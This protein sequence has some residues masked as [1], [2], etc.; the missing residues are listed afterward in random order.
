MISICVPALASHVDV[1]LF[2]QF[3]EEHNDPEVFEIILVNDKRFGNRKLDKAYDMLQQLYDNITIIDHTMED[4][5]FWL[6]QLIDHYYNNE[7][8]PDDTLDY[9]SNKLG[10]YKKGQLFEVHKKFLWLSSSRLYNL[11]AKHATGDIL[12]FSPADFLY[13]FSLSELNDYVNTHSVDGM[14][15][16]KPHAAWCEVSD[17]ET[18][19]LKPRFSEGIKQFVRIY[20]EPSL[21][22][23]RDTYFMDRK[24]NTPVSL[25]TPNIFD[26]FKE[27]LSPGQDYCPVS[28]GFH[29]FHVMT[30]KSYDTI[31]G[32]TEVAYGRAIGDNAMTHLGLSHMTHNLPNHMCI[33][34]V[35]QSDPI[36]SH[37]IYLHDGKESIAR[38]LEGIIN[39]NDPPIQFNWR[40]NHY[41]T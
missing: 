22:Q 24:S 41:T 25:D 31:G 3:L 34:W 1:S 21:M 11:A 4:S 10:L 40:P 29:G 39:L 28:Y 2:I 20:E 32:F 9:L 8:L 35:H 12:L 38:E 26:R 16:S 33:A 7:I 36:V 37:A 14:F 17:D 6:E 15:Y 13:M 19:T 27:L 18:H 23:L 30:R 5:I